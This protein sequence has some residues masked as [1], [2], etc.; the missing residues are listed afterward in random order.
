MVGAPIAPLAFRGKISPED[1]PKLASRLSAFGGNQAEGL[2]VKNLKRGLFGKFVNLEF[3]KHISD[4]ATWG[5][6]HPMQ[7]G[8]K[9]IRRV[10]GRYL[11][12]VAS[13][14]TPEQF[15]HMWHRLNNT[16]GEMREFIRYQAQLDPMLRTRRSYRWQQMVNAGNEYIRAVMTLKNPPPGKIKKLELVARMFIAAKR[17]PHDL[18]AWWEKNVALVNLALEMKDW[19]DKVADANTLFQVGPFTVH[20]IIGARGEELDNLRGSLEKAEQ[21]IKQLTDIVPG[22][23]KV[24]YGDVYLVGKISQARVM[25]F[26]MP[27]S[28]DVY[29]I[30][31]KHVG[32]T[33]VHNLI[34][35]LGHRFWHKFMGH[36]AQ[37]R[38]GSHYYRTS[39]KGHTVAEP[40]AGD[41]LE[42][43][44]IKG[45][46]KPLIVQKVESGIVYFDE[47]VK[48]SWPKIRPLLGQIANF[49]SVYASTSGSEFF[50][51]SLAFAA[52]GKLASEHVAA[53]EG[54]FKDLPPPD[55]FGRA[56]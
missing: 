36:T 7:K 16:V 29:V 18:F 54:A 37:M 50:C 19:P 8:I 38:W 31:F 40:K 43:F 20:N 42:G 11:T 56:Y 14:I 24:L 10:A 28:D 30:P 52:A 21:G 55:I 39:I 22:F 45:F 35:E 41:L 17:N 23:D 13:E 2:V 9:N 46:K 26:Y 27:K 32:T 3:M 47:N 25:A 44:A 15:D 53:L 49:P 6:A 33:E 5:G 12:R 34:H 1:L 51:E 48:L 4:E